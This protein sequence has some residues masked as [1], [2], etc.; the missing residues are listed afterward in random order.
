MAKLVAA[1]AGLLIAASASSVIAAEV[2]TE[3][4]KRS[5]LRVCADP[6]NLP[7]SNRAK[8]GFENKI[9]ELLS[10][11][12]GIPLAYTWFPHTLGFV[13][14]TLRARRC[15]LVIGVTAA[16]ELMQN[17]NP[18]YSSVFAVVQRKDADYEIK[19]LT[20][21]VIKERKLRIGAVAGTPPNNIL[22][23]EGMMSQVRPFHLRRGDLREK[24]LEHMEGE[25]LNDKMDILV[26]WGPI[27]GY[28]TRRN[29]E[30]LKMTPLTADNASRHRMIFPITMGMRRS[31]IKW[32]REVNRLLRKNKDEIH[33]ILEEYNVPLVEEEI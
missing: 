29:P 27:A 11:K 17:S 33:A 8:E 10:E 18:Y 22:L 5:V 7:F 31:E 19:S 2:G 9:A 3:L 6:A 25:L 12:L 16:H 15:D 1:V 23:Q 30:V 26:L 20:D 32:R 24:P 13:R 21:A 28:I 14:L 4:G